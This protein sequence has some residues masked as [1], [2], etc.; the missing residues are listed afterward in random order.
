MVFAVVY[1][2]EADEYEDLR[3]SL[4]KLQ[5]NDVSLVFEPESRYSWFW[6]QMRIPWPSPP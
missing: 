2:V 1:P 6:F 3:A 4:E 5:L